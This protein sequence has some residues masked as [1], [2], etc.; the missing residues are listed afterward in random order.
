MKLCV[1]DPDGLLN[2]TEF[3]Q[4]AVFVVSALSYLQHLQSGRG[5]PDYVAGHSVGEYAAL[6]AA[7]ALDFESALG[8]VKA[9]AEVMSRLGNGGLAAVIGHDEVGTRQL[10]DRLGV[11]GIEIANLNTPDQ[12]VVGGP[13]SSLE[14]FV[15]ACSAA[16]V[17]AI[18]LRV[19]GAF[20]TSLMSNA[21]AAF[22]DT[23]TAT[24]FKQPVIPV[25]SNVTGCPYGAGE[26]AA[27]LGQQIDHAVDW[28]SGIAYLMD[29]GVDD[30]TEFPKGGPLTAMVRKI[31]TLRS[32]GSVKRQ[33]AG[34]KPAQTGRPS[35]QS[36]FHTDSRIVFGGVDDAE[37]NRSIIEGLKGTNILTSLQSDGR[38]LADL[39]TD[40]KHL[41]GA[42]VQKDN[43]GLSISF[44][45]YSPDLTE[46]LIA[47]AQTNR[48]GWIQLRGFRQ[49]P[50]GI[51]D[52]GPATRHRLRVIA[53]TNAIRDFEHLLSNA[54]GRVPDAVSIDVGQWRSHAA[55]SPKDAYAA[56]SAQQR[57][58]TVRR[59]ERR[60]LVGI[61]GTIADSNDVTAA[62]T[63]GFD[64]VIAETVFQ[65]LDT[66]SGIV[67]AFPDWQFPEFGSRTLC[68]LPSPEVAQR[69]DRLEAIYNRKH[70]SA[71][72]LATFLKGD[73]E[74]SSLRDE[75]VPGT[76][77]PRAQLRQIAARYF[78]KYARRCEPVDHNAGAAFTPASSKRPTADPVAILH[79]LTKGTASFGTSHSS[80]PSQGKS[81]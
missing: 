3:T 2:Q 65:P 6:V 34:L 42:G 69:L 7:G 39:E 28:V 29:S 55:V 44:N 58:E 9:R 61:G 41:V 45:P 66:G 1:D 71:Q 56:L 20:H 77:S 35:F 51:F 23:L 37:A 36:V 17:R 81:S 79:H 30:W 13:I 80:L 14:D 27:T 54:H 16:D 59:S 50:D 19:S 73:P 25:I 47:F 62:I 48:L 57:L 40:L 76:Q 15:A 21:A 70:Q 52:E 10:I 31:E 22:R 12:T 38:E 11:N 64:F 43:L 26:I 68:R 4:P 53:R 46:R 63:A 5:R 72:E 74:L 24:K 60:V 32:S 8:L 49:L 18:P 67:G 75:M 78:A 33:P